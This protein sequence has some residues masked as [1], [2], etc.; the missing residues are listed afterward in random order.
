ME[1]RKDN[2]KK[3]IEQF[4][5][6]T[7]ETK[8][9]IIQILQ[10][11]H[12]KDYLIYVHHV[13]FENHY[14][15]QIEITS[16]YMNKIYRMTSYDDDMFLKHILFKQYQSMNFQYVTLSTL[17]EDI[18][19][20]IGISSELLKLYNELSENTL[21]QFE[22]QCLK[23]SKKPYLFSKYKQLKC[24]MMFQN[25]LKQIEKD[26]V[27]R[28][29]VIRW[30]EINFYDSESNRERVKNVKIIQSE[31]S[32]IDYNEI[33][34]SQKLTSSTIS[35]NKKIRTGILK[36]YMKDNYPNETFD[37]HKLL[38]TIDYSYRIFLLDQETIDI[39]D[40][41]L[42]YMKEQV[43]VAFYLFEKHLISCNQLESILRRNSSLNKHNIMKLVNYELKL[44]DCK[45][46]IIDWKNSEIISNEEYNLLLERC[47]Q[48]D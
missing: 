33:T 4:P 35:R 39:L 44:N 18:N 8:Q 32:F 48:N 27:T 43:D 25:Y 20:E 29:D 13:I 45:Q 22:S 28:D 1:E 30:L 17:E 41:E 14:R 26:E 36:K 16:Y 34:K 3:L 12:P 46:S 47:S 10:K 40:K 24:E 42:K 2:W 7:P 6:I 11:L 21:Q 23:E 5:T 37:Q 9:K 31:S 38:T 15:I 19:K